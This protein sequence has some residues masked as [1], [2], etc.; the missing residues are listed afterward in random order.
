MEIE[1]KQ[2]INML[3]QSLQLLA[4]NYERQVKAFP[5]YVHV[6]DEIALTFDDTYTLVASLRSDGLVTPAQEH[7]LGQIDTLLE[8]M[9]Q[10]ENV[11]TCEELRTS[12]QWEDVRQLARETLKAFHTPRQNPN[13]F[14]LHYVPDQQAHIR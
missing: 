10:D 5:E 14:W 2:H 1:S 4:A 3:L 11:W 8:K 12:S 7:K 9:S 13:L 6:P